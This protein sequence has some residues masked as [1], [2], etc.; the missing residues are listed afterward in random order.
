M[1]RHRVVF[2]HPSE[3]EFARVLDF[4][5]IEW[6]YEPTTFPL[7]WDERGA[8][9]EAFTPD[10]YLVQEDLY[11]ELTTLRPKLMRFKH[12]K[13]RRI[14]ELYPDIN[15]RLWNRSDFVHFLERFGLEQESA[16][17]IGKDAKR[18]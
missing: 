14:K 2:S 11:V 3:E 13:I 8:I 16:M 4:Y 1:D 10:F 6:R 15:I 17:L 12:R 5:G 7:H 18:E 9:V